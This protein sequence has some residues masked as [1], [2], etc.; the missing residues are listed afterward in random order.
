M[1]EYTL[2]KLDTEAAQ[3]TVHNLNCAELASQEPGRYLGS[4]GNPQAAYAK[5]VGMF[6]DVSCCPQCIAAS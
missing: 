3:Y 5:A 6:S 4:Y 2:Q 1:A